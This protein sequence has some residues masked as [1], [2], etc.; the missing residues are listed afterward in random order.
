MSQFQ[1][2]GN[3]IGVS[4]LNLIVLAA[5]VTAFHVLAA[6]AM[7]G[8]T[9]PMSGTY[10]IGPGGDY[11]SFSAA[12]A[13][14][15]D[16]KVGGD[17][18]LLIEPG[19]YEEKLYINMLQT[20]QFQISPYRLT[21]RSAS[22]N[23]E[24]VILKSSGLVVSMHSNARNVTFENFT[25]ETTRIG[26]PMF[27]IDGNSHI[28]SRM[29]FIGGHLSGANYSISLRIENCT[30]LRS[31]ISFLGQQLAG[32]SI[33]GNTF[34][35]G[36]INMNSLRGG[37]LISENVIFNRTNGIHIQNAPFPARIFNNYVHVETGRAL[38]LHT[39]GSVLVYHNTLKSHY[40]GT[41]L[42][43][44][45]EANIHLKNNIL[46]STTG[47][48]MVLEFLE[49]VTS[50]FNGFYTGRDVFA[51]SGSWRGWENYETYGD[52]IAATGQDAN[53]IFRDPRFDSEA[54]DSLQRMMPGTS[55]FQ[56][57]GMYLLEVVPGDLMGNP[58]PAAPSLGALE[59]VGTETSAPGN[60]QDGIT[61]LPVEFALTGNYPNPFN[62]STTIRYELHESTQVTLT[63]FD[64]Y[65]RRVAILVSGSKEAGSHAA[66]FD[67]SGL[68]SG[69]YL[70]RLSS[71]AQSLTGKMV[72][73]K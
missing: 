12:M 61:A 23:A 51:R 33:I 5:A 31:S 41:A 70:Y 43:V 42:K 3:R 26:T 72:L 67:A 27:E 29:T 34:Y 20:P 8:P 48:V 14:I 21:F 54:E 30:F 37:Y 18:L 19:I 36:S 65:G 63:V 58:R 9:G 49:S 50:D 40:S 22:P 62:P 16:R 47:Y 52:F 10:G 60:E 69:V 13:D 73:A 24:D 1:S 68:A 39:V 55:A 7:A 56:T 28:I 71:P 25:I 64:V 32:V 2:K 38:Y 45:S 6:S 59:Y 4:T 44:E 35:N 46:F 66:V 11:S 15:Q 53:S 57:A 17:I